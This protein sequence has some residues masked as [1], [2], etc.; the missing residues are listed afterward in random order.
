MSLMITGITV[1]QT[2]PAGTL[3]G[4]LHAYNSGVT[5]P[6]SFILRLRAPA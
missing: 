3:V 5:V 1:R 4:Y 6:S 2:A